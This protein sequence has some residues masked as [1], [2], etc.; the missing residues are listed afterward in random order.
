M[1]E[2]SKARP[3]VVIVKYDVASIQ[4]ELDFFSILLR[5]ALAEHSI[6]RLLGLSYVVTVASE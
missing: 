3:S 1:G 6:L 2:C 5:K 4:G